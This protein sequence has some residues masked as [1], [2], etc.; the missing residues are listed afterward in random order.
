MYRQAGVDA[1]QSCMEAA[2]Q[3]RPLSLPCL[4]RV[5]PAASAIELV[6]W[7]A[8]RTTSKIHHEQLGRSLGKSL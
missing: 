1:R 4:E 7:L 5:L 8:H 2:T 6:E 3:A